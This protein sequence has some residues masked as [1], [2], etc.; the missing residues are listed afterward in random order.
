MALL[1]VNVGM[2]SGMTLICVSLLG[3]EI[4]GL[5]LAAILFNVLECLLLLLVV[6][7]FSLFSNPI[8]ASIISTLILFLGHAVKETQ[9]TSFVQLRP[10][11]GKLLE[12]YHLVL[13]A[14]Y[15]L[16]LKEFVTYNQHVDVSYLL[17]SGCYGLL[18]SSF[19]LLMIIT[20]FNKKNID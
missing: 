14:F 19:L 9:M 6:V 1:I 7:L 15:K 4:S 11:I 17:N 16:N 8:L 18:Y 2:L 20:L 3:G 12:F 5:M 10:F 13:P